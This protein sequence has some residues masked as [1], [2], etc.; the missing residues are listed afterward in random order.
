MGSRASWEPRGAAIL[1][2]LA[3]PRSATEVAGR[4]SI[5]PAGASHHLTALRDAGLVTGRRQGRA[6]LYVRT[7]LGEA[8]AEG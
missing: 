3:A 5:S 1:A 2:G 7:P 4:L 8:L 6:V